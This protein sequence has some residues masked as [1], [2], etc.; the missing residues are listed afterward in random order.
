MLEDKV[1]QSTPEIEASQACSFRQ[2]SDSQLPVSDVISKLTLNHDELIPLYER[3][4]EEGVALGASETLF[5]LYKLAV[6][7]HMEKRSLKKFAKNP[8]SQKIESLADMCQWNDD[9]N[10]NAPSGWI[11]IYPLREIMSCLR[12]DHELNQSFWH[13]IHLFPFNRD[14]MDYNS[15]EGLFSNV[16]S[17][18]NLDS[19]TVI[20]FYDKLIE[21]GVEY[22]TEPYPFTE[23]KNGTI[24]HDHSKYLSIGI[25]TATNPYPHLD[26]AGLGILVNVYK[27]GA[28]E[29]RKMNTLKE[30]VNSPN[31]RAI[32][33]LGLAYG[34]DNATGK[35]V[36]ELK[37]LYDLVLKLHQE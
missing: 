13:F 23:R 29:H 27:F 37:K 15:D 31:S 9:H 14:I 25:R 28:E 30:F 33:D 20:P 26:R 16:V 11:D 10:I 18:F 2:L 19:D 1:T 32:E 21:S 24:F 17:Q 35:A 5:G 7:A 4:I 8:S 36:P 6:D 12:S 34:H 22:A 3:L